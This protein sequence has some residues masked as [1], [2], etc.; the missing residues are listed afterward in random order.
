[1]SDPL[2]E[3]V[4]FLLDQ[5]SQPWERPAQAHEAEKLQK[6]ILRAYAETPVKPSKPATPRYRVGRKVPLNIYDGD[7]PV[8]QTHDPEDAA[9]IVAALNA[10]EDSK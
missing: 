8:C 9:L 2:K 6:A 1:M 10:L 5:L 7:R 4:L 3:A